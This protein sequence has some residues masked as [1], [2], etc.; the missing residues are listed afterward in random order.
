MDLK[1]KRKGFSKHRKYCRK[2]HPEQEN[3]PAGSLVQDGKKN[4]GN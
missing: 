4:T 2:C 1:Y 3:R